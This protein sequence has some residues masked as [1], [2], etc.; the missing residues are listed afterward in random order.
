[1]TG[2]LFL[3]LLLLGLAGFFWL[4][5]ASSPDRRKLQAVAETRQLLHTQGFK[6]DVNEF[7]FSTPPEMR[8]REALLTGAY[9]SRGSQQF[10]GQPALMQPVGTN[11]ALVLWKQNLLKSESRSSGRDAEEITWGEFASAVNVSPLQ[12]DA[13]SA[14][15]LS[16]P[17]GFNLDARRGSTMLLK[18]LAVVKTLGQAF[19]YRTVLALHEG[20]P[21]TAWTNLLAGTRLVTAWEPEPSRTSHMVRLA[22]A[23]SSYNALWQALQ[24]NSW[25]DDRL[26]QLQQEWSAVDFFK[27]LPEIVAFTRASL[28]RDC[29]Q[30]RHRT[31]LDG[32]TLGEFTKEMLHHPNYAWPRW[33]E[34]Q[35]QLAYA[36]LGSYDDETNL[37]LFFRDRELVVRDAIK[38]SNWSQIRQV[39]GVG[40]NIVFQSEYGTYLSELNFKT[41]LLRSSR[42]TPPMVV[43]MGQ[44]DS[45]VFYERTAELE[46]M[47]Q[48]LVTALALERFHGKHSS[49]P[50]D[51][52]SLVPEF[53]KIAPV[54]F[55]NG[56][57]L[58]YRLNGDGHFLLYS[59]GLDGVDNGGQMRRTWFA[60]GY[61]H[62][63]Q[64]R[65]GPPE[66]DIV[67]PLPA[68]DSAQREE[69]QM[70]AE[71]QKAEQKAKE[72]FQRRYL[73]EISDREWKTSRARQ[74]QTDKILSLVR[75]VDPNDPTFKGVPVGS[76]IINT[77]VTGT[78]R[79]T[80]EALLTPKQII[81]GRE[82]EEITLELPIRYDAFATN[83]I[84]FPVVDADPEAGLP[85]G[86]GKV[87]ERRCATNGDCLLVWHTIYDPPG[88]HAVQVYL[89][90]DDKVEGTLYGMGPPVTITTSNLCQF[91]VDCANYETATGA[92]FHARLP[93]PNG[94]YTIECL[95][96]NGEHLTTLTGTTTTGEFKAVWNLVDD[97]GDRLNGETFDTKVQITLP[98]SGRRQTLR[99]PRPD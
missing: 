28:V 24:T 78:N 39:L 86:G 58:H 90:L 43:E 7:D 12:V 71:V 35:K 15:I 9:L 94:V 6:T 73:A 14:A 53:L 51:L 52:T 74:S 33:T 95:G 20:N 54:D 47:R 66:F 85:D 22:C 81:T 41:T 21:D 30:D 34:Y 45:D 64:P 17:I 89:A 76:L 60:L 42:G 67:W 70:Q 49:Y 65:S 56:Q 1:M 55:M 91:S 31:F 79:L 50:A 92:I 96:T 10:N 29:E 48:I 38:A 72:S 83:N 97:R 69:Q 4:S 2:Y 98:D 59:V 84:V 93:E 87:Y 3:T 40:T 19:G 61:E 25:S 37:M 63:T 13:A 99:G 27:N 26:A 11:S 88:R 57:P 46:T 32:E 62:T 8:A 44:R 68:G 18:H 23:V 77:N 80:L 82:P 5:S 75:V 16:G 36:R